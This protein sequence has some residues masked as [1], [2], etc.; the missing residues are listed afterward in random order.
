MSRPW[1]ALIR[2]TAAVGVLALAFLGG[3]RADDTIRIGVPLEL[4]GRFVDY[5]VPA[6]R[7]VQMAAE[8]FNNTVLGKKVEFVFRDIQSN[9]QTAASVM[10]EL[11][12]QLKLRYLIG[13]IS[14]QN[15]ESMIPIW[16]QD[17]DRP[18]WTGCNP[19]NPEVEKVVGIYPNYFHTFPYAYDYQKA[20]AAT[21]QHYLGPGKKVGV[22]YVDDIYGREHLKY[23]HQYFEEDKETIV[24]EELV[25][26]NSTDFSATLIKMKRAK[27]DLVLAIMQTNDAIN[28]ARQ[29]YALKLGVPYVFGLVAPGYAQWQQAVGPAQEGWV[30]LS[31]YLPNTITQAAD[32]KYPKIFPSMKDWEDAVR[33]RFH[34]EPDYLTAEY[35]SV[36]A[37]LLLAMQEA[38]TD[39]MAKVQTVMQN[40]HVDTPFGKADFKPTGNGTIN[41]SFNDLLVFQRKDNKNVLLWPLDKAAGDKLEP[42]TQ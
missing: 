17:Q 22:V 11:V 27:P 2:R 34:V 9:P 14:S 8:A 42:M 26:T 23:A 12:N 29:A 30:G 19:T 13:P 18:L 37:L 33:A 40:L 35:Y 21:A 28:F 38:G 5:G 1:S 36:T 41:Q 39:D 25:R 10:N 6:Q 31:P 16:V 3:A 4:S 15:I 32:P 7:G 20:L 24:A